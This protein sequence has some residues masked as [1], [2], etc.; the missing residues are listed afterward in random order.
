MV[1][2]LIFSIKFQQQRLVLYFLLLIQTNKPILS[3]MIQ[4][5]E[6]SLIPSSSTFSSSSLYSGLASIITLCGNSCASIAHFK[7]STGSI[8]FPSSTSPSF[9][10]LLTALDIKNRIV[11]TLSFN[12]SQTNRSS[13]LFLAS[14]SVDT[15]TLLGTCETNFVLND[16]F[17]LSNVNFAYDSI[18]DTVIIASCIDDLCIAPLNITA[19]HPKSCSSQTLASIPVQEVTIGGS[20]AIDPF[21]RIFLFTVARPTS[22]LALIAFNISSKTILRIIPETQ[23]TPYIQSLVFDT[24][25]RLVYGLAFTTA[26]YSQPSLVSINASTGKLKTIGQVNNCNG[27]LPDSLAVS[28]DGTRLFFIGS[29]NTSTDSTIL[30]SIYTANATIASSVSVQDGTLALGDA[31]NSLFWVS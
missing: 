24:V 3:S 9:Y 20:G 12:N 23:D 18:T 11:H 17:D 15:S 19:I 28:D 1:L 22:G 6:V 4:T 10:P 21:A 25:S 29:S 13:I 2:L 30:Y 27:A 5:N 16:G 7:I 26:G 8:S 14:I 31:P